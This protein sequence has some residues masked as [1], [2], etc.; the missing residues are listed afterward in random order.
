[1]ASEAAIA[2]GSLGDIA[3]PTLAAFLDDKSPRVRA[4]AAETLG[5]TG[6]RGAVGQLSKLLQD[7]DANVRATAIRALGEI[8]PASRAAV[9]SLIQCA[10]PWAASL[11]AK[12]RRLPRANSACGLALCGKPKTGTVPG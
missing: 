1:M 7:E 8:G 10:S 5:R 11:A 12:I 6:A 4:L 2:L 3:E 9:P